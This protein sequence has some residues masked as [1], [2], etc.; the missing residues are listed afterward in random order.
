MRLYMFSE[1][2]KMASFCVTSDL[3][4]SS[5]CNRRDFARIW[6]RQLAITVNNAKR[7]F[8]P[9]KIV[10]SC[11]F[12]PMAA[13]LRAESENLTPESALGVL[14]YVFAS[15]QVLETCFQ[16]KISASS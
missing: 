6:H 15:L 3:R 7:C 4:D 11:F 2:V 14:C 9:R 16:K 12:F 1:K 8:I 10:E 13:K 5:C